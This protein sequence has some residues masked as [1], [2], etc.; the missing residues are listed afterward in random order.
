M[1]TD[2]LE[3]KIAY[4]SKYII[5]VYEQLTVS[6]LVVFWLER[7]PNAPTPWSPIDNLVFHENLRYKIVLWDDLTMGKQSVSPIEGRQRNI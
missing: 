6:L 2:F 1:F 5:Q 7:A 3:L 4:I